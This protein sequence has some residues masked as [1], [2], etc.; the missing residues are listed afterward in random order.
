VTI[1]N[2]SNK[3]REIMDEL[4][5]FTQTADM[6]MLTRNLNNLLKS[7]QERLL[8][9]QIRSFIPND[10]KEAFE[11]LINNPSLANVLTD[12]KPQPSLLNVNVN[13]YQLKRK[14]KGNQKF[15]DTKK[16]V[17]SNQESLNSHKR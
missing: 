1:P 12:P 11:Y 5:S 6:P 15:V 2:N 7:P 17:H 8:L 3:R 9:E 14:E 10:K 13:S 4:K 16:S